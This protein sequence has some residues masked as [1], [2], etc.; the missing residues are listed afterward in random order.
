MALNGERIRSLVAEARGKY[1]VARAAFTDEDIFEAEMR[2]IWEGNWI[3]LCHESQLPKPNDFLTTWIGRQPVIINRDK[4]GRLGGFINA[5]TH[6]GA[7]LCRERRGHAAVFTCPFHGWAFHSDGTLL[8]VR[9]E[10]DGA[11]SAEFDKSAHALKAVPRVESYRGFIFGS[12]NAEVEPLSSHLGDARYFIDLLVDQ[13][14][15]GLE[16]VRGSSTYVYKGNWK[17]QAENGA[18]GYHVAAVHHNYVS[19]LRNREQAAQTVNP[20]AITPGG[21]GNR[22]S[23]FYAF[24]NGHVVIWSERGN[25]AASPN[26]PRQEQYRQQ[27]GEDRAFWMLGRSRNLGVYPNLF[28]MDSMSTQ[29]RRTRAL[30]V[31]ATEVTTFCFAPIGESLETRTK[32]IRQ[33]EDFYNASGMA[34]PDDLAEF[35]ASQSGFQ[36]RLLAWSDLS[37]GAERWIRGP[38][39]LARRCGFDAV[40]SGPRIEDEG[41]FVMQH[42]GWQA[43]MLAGLKKDGL[44]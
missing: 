5:C 4:N 44:S 42:K 13:A 37:H 1:A 11:Y 26:F 23:G 14:P 32:R 43:K 15:E 7:T 20:E 27:Y 25:P 10:K 33:Y 22:A 35:K 30:S 17:L 24:D 34:T 18:D 31:D 41:L 12:L 9:G 16:L 6:R 19:M 21:I 40:M 3:F 39:E 29:I 36:G 2:Y 38:D 28:L 8:P